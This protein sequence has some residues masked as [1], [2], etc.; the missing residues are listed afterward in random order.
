M[1]G[2]Y[3]LICPLTVIGG[4]IS[5]IIMEL[6]GGFFQGNEKWPLRSEMQAKGTNIYQCPNR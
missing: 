5:K 4:N 3:P 6:L 2:S 1:G